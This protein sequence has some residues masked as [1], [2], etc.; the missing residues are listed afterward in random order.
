MSCPG[1]HVQI[2]DTRLW[3]VERGEGFPLLVLHGGPGL[4]HHEFGHYLDPLG[5]RYR[6]V[7]VDQRSQGLSDRAPELT[8]TLERM[9][10]DVIM[11]ARDGTRAV[12]GPR[13]LVRR[14]VDY[15]GLATQPL[16]MNPA[17]AC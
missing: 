16:V 8:W 13:P 7:L 6:L 5:D 2:D 10:Q 14:V 17:S 9:A 3:V 4:D 15:P 1:R 12:R 11:L